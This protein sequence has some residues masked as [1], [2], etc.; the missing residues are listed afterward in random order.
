M[1][2][3]RLEERSWI[4]SVSSD[5]RRQP[6]TIIPAG[7]AYLTERLEQ[8]LSGGAS[9]ISATIS[10]TRSIL[11]GQPARKRD[12]A[13]ATFRTLTVR[14]DLSTELEFAVPPVGSCTVG[15]SRRDGQGQA[16]AVPDYI[17]ADALSVFPFREKTAAYLNAG[18]VEITR[19]ISAQPLDADSFTRYRVLRG[20]RT[21]RRPVSLIRGKRRQSRMHKH[22]VRWGSSIS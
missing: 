20:P 18:S 5:D 13:L 2:I 10:L 9:L 11:A 8:Q 1:A 7:S 16:P 19:D 6:S 17:P 3:T 12:F 21:S 4:R 14:A 15:Q 22:P